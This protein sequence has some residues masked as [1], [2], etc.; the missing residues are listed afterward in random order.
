MA[1]ESVLNGVAAEGEDQ[2]AESFYDFEAETTKV[3]DLVKKVE[4]LEREKVELVKENEEVKEK[5]RKWEKEV[6]ELRSEKEKMEELVKKAGEDGKVVDAIAGRAADL[7]TEVS[8]L[9]HDLVSAMSEGDE[10]NAELREMKKELEE[11]KLSVGKLEREKKL[12]KEGFLAEIE[13]V[14]K[15]KAVVEAKVGE[16]EGKIKGIEE[17]PEAKLVLKESE[18]SVLKNKVAEWEAS[19]SSSASELHKEKAERKALEEALKTSEAKV[20]ELEAKLTQLQKKVK[21]AERVVSGIKETTVEAVNGVVDRDAV[22]VDE[23]SNKGTINLQWAVGAGAT[24][25]VVG[26]IICLLYTRRR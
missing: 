8:R 10:A 16:L 26:G 17:E 25:V 18:I 13:E 9:Q 2:T 20:S 12:M 23:G 14:K 22:L 3:S 21:E 15:A 1:D 24:A 4:V 5:V 19:V 11:K 6:L 7:E